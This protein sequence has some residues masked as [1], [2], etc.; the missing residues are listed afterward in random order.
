MPSLV[1][2]DISLKFHVRAYEQS[3]GSTNTFH[4]PKM[5]PQAMAFRCNA[6]ITV[7][8][9][10]KVRNLEDPSDTRNMPCMGTLLVES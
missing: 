4:S 8:Q 6:F 7:M 10:S 1:T 9:A 5:R 2:F 3:V